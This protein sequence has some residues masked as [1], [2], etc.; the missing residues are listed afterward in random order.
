MFS[1][2]AVWQAPV[3]WRLGG[4]HIIFDG[5]VSLFRFTLNKGQTSPISPIRHGDTSPMSFRQ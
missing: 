2:W 5:P 1:F 4:D 3:L